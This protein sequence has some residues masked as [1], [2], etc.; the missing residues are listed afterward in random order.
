MTAS[1]LEMFVQQGAEQLRLWMGIDPPTDL[2]RDCVYQRLAAHTASH[3][4]VKHED[5]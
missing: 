2:M 5:H 1:G 4:Q 3:G